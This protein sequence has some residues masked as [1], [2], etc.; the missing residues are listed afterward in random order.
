MNGACRCCGLSRP[1]P[2]PALA[3]ARLNGPR[4]RH[5]TLRVLDGLRLRLASVRD[6][7]CR[8]CADDYSR[9]VMDTRAA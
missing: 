2:L 3:L 7:L 1:G 5:L 9:K 4:V 6:L 8:K